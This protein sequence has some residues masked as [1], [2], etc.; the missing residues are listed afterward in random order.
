MCTIM[1]YG[2]SGSCV[3]EFASTPLHGESRLNKFV[4]KVAI[5]MGTV[6][7]HVKILIHFKTSVV[8]YFRARQGGRCKQIDFL[9]KHLI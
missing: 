4:R 8:E 1:F 7:S 9:D 3:Y 6:D 2:E 5:K